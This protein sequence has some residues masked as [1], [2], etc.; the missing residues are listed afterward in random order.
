LETIERDYA[1][2]GV[3]FYYIYKALAHP[4]T[5]GY[6][7]PFSLEE[8]LMHVAEAKRTLGS[9]IEWICDTMDN[10][11]K[12][13]LGDRP[14]SEFVI[15]PSGKVVVSR[16]WSNPSQ[17]R[18]DL[19][20][21][22]GEV[23]NP[24]SISDL[25][26]KK[27]APPQ[28]AARGVVER[29]DLPGRMSPVQITPVESKTPHY[30]KLRAESG[31]GKLYLGFFLDPLYK[32]H[33]NNKAPALEYSIES[34]EGVSV[35]PQS[36]NG[37]KVE[38]DADADP[39]EFLIDVS[40]RSSDPLKV[41]VK[42]FACDDAETF[43]IP[44]TQQYLVSFERDRDGGNRRASGGRGGSRGG[45]GRGPGRGPGGSPPSASM[46]E[47]MQRIPV[48]AALDTDRDG[49]LSA[50]ELESAPE[51]L[52]TIDRDGDGE[53]G[54]AEIRPGFAP[55][56]SGLG[57]NR[58]SMMIRMFTENDRNNDGKLSGDEIPDPMRE[59]MGTMD[60]DRDGSISRSEIEAMSG[61]RGGPG[62]R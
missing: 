28:K 1:Q 21:L 30:A 35:T 48:M 62:G 36:G 58:S 33:W 6:V 13:A 15:D 41:T 7:A 34:P 31:D 53:L 18:N 60:R 24:T 50:E 19:T 61:R 45:P 27:L 23:E 2:Q 46:R 29:V 3:K 37:P 55:T 16:S 54:A 14:N 57:Q 25:D 17:L 56:G 51:S 26:M 38:V 11:L 43:C 9:R 47:M 32:V 39:R 22:V 40:G 10:D 59:R 12:H 5:N 52:R 49:T 20:E 8:R 4:E 44:V 42:Y